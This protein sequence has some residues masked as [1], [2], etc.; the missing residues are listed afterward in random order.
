MLHRFNGRTWSGS[1]PAIGRRASQQIEVSGDPIKY[2]VTME[3]TR[4][5][6]VFALDLP[7]RWDLDQTF[8][9]RQQ[10]LARVYPIDQ[11]I[12]YEAQSYTNYRSQADLNSFAFDWYVTLPQGTNPEAAQFARELRAQVDSDQAFVDALLKYFNDEE[13]FYTLEPPALGRNPVDQ[14]LFNTR[15]GFCEHY[16]SAFSVLTRSIGIPSRVVVGYQGGEL[17]PMGN[18]MIVRQSDAHAWAEVWF[19]ELGWVRV[20]PTA[21]VAPER[22][23]LGVAES[24]FDG[25]G[26]EWG[27]SASSQLLHQLILSWDAMNAKWNDWILGYGPDKQN[28]LM[29]FLGM[30]DPSWRK[31]ML[32]LIS[33]VIVII[34]L[35]SGV[36]ALRYRPPQ[37]DPAAAMYRRFVKKTGVAIKV[38]EAPDAYAARLIELRPEIPPDVIRR[39]TDSYLEARYGEMG[40]DALPHLQERVVEAISLAG[41]PALRSATS[42]PQ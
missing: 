38:G 9:G 23:E 8:M 29:N 30:E 33:C 34:V 22:I 11:R 39:V 28:S 35:V 19:P 21:A 6:F 1:D 27:L 26:M 3:P 24:I 12:A 10:A 42:R 40:P 2:Q 15:R 5:H 20:D 7:Y 18:Y 37:S 31:M 16:A 4:Q 41:R 14:F 13:F 17:N 25:I 36:L 32:T